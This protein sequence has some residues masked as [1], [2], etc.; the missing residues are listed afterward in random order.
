MM[1]INKHHNKWN[2]FNQLIVQF[3]VHHIGEP[4]LQQKQTLVY[5]TSASISFKCPYNAKP[6]AKLTWLKDGQLFIPELIELVKEINI[7]FKI[8]I[9]YYLV[10]N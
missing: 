6:K 3:N 10:Y 9:S 7:Y 1:V 8:F 5:P 4:V 2:Y